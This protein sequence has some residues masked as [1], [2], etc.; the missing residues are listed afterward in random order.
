[1]WQIYTQQPATGRSMWD[2]AE[3]RALEGFI[4]A[5][6]P[7]NFTS[8]AGTLPTAPALMGNTVIWKP[9]S[10][11]VYTGYYLMRLFEAAGMPP[12]VIN[13]VPGDGS[14]LS[15]VALHHPSLAGI[16]FTGST[17]VFQMMWRTVGENIQKY[18]TYPRL[19]GETGGKDFI[20]AH[21]SADRD[22]L[23]TAILRGGFEYQGQKCS[24]V[25]RVYVPDTLW[26]SIKD[27]LLGHTSGIAMGDVADFRNFMGAVIDRAAY[28]KIAA[29]IEEARHSSDA[30]ILVGG[31]ADDSTG[32]FI[33]PTIIEAKRPDYRTMCEE[34]FGPVVTLY[35][36]PERQ[37]SETLKLEIG[38]ARLNSSH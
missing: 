24:A 28:N 3:Y 20:V 38:R 32:Y 4:L 6:T 23:V 12:G 35:V 36:Y 27:D 22:A 18:R 2:Y 19:V 33:R 14:A 30:S 26:R 16:H 8:I 10:S 31:E 21:A 17:G 37:W 1:M 7:F 13:F 9:A 25:S 11:T 29:Y 5:V 15:Q 34:I